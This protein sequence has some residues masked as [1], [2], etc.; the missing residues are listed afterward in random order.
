MARMPGAVWKPLA[1]NWANQPALNAPDII[2]IHTMVGSLAGTDSYFR[3]GNGAGFSGTESHFGTGA[4]GEI[5]Q[6]QDTSRQAEANFNGNGHI[7]SIENADYGAGFPRWNTNDGGAVPAFTAAQCEAIA[8]ILAWASKTHNIPLVLVPNS[9]RGNRGVAYHA[10]GVPSRSGASVSQTGGE[11][12]SLAVGKVCPGSRRIAQ[13]PGIIKRARVLA[14]LDQQEED[15]PLTKEDVEKV[16]KRTVELLLDETDLNPDMDARQSV[17]NV[18][19]QI[20]TN[21]KADRKSAE[22][23]AARDVASAAAVKEL[24]KVVADREGFDPLEVE[25]AVNKAVDDALAG[26]LVADVDSVD[27]NIQP[28]A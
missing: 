13:I 7:I 6:W 5:T 16:A 1:S 11:L 15:M 26:K 17:R 18:V 22:A 10:Q 8:K 28:S 27:L 21:G 14:G 24:S 19:L 25:Q 4:S 23:A 12:W 20:W 9:K 2:C 3:S